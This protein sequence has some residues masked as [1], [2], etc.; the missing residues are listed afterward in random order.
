VQNFK[1]YFKKR[2][3]DF[4]QFLKRRVVFLKKDTFKYTKSKECVPKGKT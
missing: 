1:N 4:G 3:I 2:K